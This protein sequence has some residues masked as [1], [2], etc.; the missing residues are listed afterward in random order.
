MFILLS[1]KGYVD[2]F[3]YF[4][5]NYF[6]FVWFLKVKRLGMILCLVFFSFCFVVIYELYSCLMW[7]LCFYGSLCGF[8]CSEKEFGL[9]FKSNIILWGKIFIISFNRMFYVWRYFLFEVLFDKV[10][11]FELVLLYFIKFKCILF[12]ILLFVF[13]IYFG[14][15]IWWFDYFNLFEFFI[16]K[17]IF[18]FSW[19]L[20]CNM[21]F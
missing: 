17:N 21:Y 1:K 8:F 6:F 19:E 7:L 2:Y 20:L 4:V 13:V 14:L 9:F 12:F 18:F 10:V 15:I 11:V 3:C 5:V 16:G